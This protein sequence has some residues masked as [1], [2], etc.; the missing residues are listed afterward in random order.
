MNLTALSLCSFGVPILLRWI[1]NFSQGIL[2]PILLLC[3]CF[4]GCMRTRASYSPILMSSLFLFQ[5]SIFS[6]IFPFYSYITFLT[7]STH[8][9]LGLWVSLRKL[10]R[11]LCLVYLLSSLFQIWFLSFPPP[12]NRPYFHISLNTHF[13]VIFSVENWT[14]EPNNVVTLDIRFSHLPRA[15]LLLLLFLLF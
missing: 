14:C 3:Q 7:F 10:L 12:V 6:H 11:S 13:F 2:I 9:P 4:Y 15:L 1:L 8:F 5:F